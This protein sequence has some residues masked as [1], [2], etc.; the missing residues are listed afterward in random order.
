MALLL[1][2]GALVPVT[3]LAGAGLSRV[4]YGLRPAQQGTV[5]G[6]LLVGS[7]V[8]LLAA[9]LVRAKQVLQPGGPG[10]GVNNTILQDDCAGSLGLIWLLLAATALVAVA[11]VELYARRSRVR[12]TRP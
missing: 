2:D 5:R 1:H 7:I 8:T 4:T 10:T 6:A 12:N 3:T 9:P 11:A